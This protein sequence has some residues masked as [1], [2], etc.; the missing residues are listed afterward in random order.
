MFEFD[1]LRGDLDGFA[2]EEWTSDLISISRAKFSDV[3]NGNLPDWRKTLSLLPDAGKHVFDLRSPTI[4]S[5]FE[6][7]EDSRSLAR[8][9]LLQFRPW[10]KGPFNISGI[11]I[12]AEW[13]SDLK[14]KRLEKSISP[15]T[16]RHVLDVG[17]GNGYYALRMRGLGA[18]SV[19]GI[20][21]TLLHV[22]QF[23]AI[24][25][26]MRPEPVH[27][28]PLRLHELPGSAPLFDTTFSMGVLYHQRDPIEHLSQL[29]QTLRSGGELVLESL[30]VPGDTSYVV[31]PD[32]R[33]A[34]MRNVWHLPTVQRLTE[35][36][37]EAG[38]SD[39]HVVD[40]TYTT[41]DEQRT[42]EW[43][44]FESLIEALDPSDSSK[45]VEGL[46]APLR[47]IIICRNPEAGTP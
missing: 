4:E 40:Q 16:D 32:D 36:L 23:A 20:D 15:L 14:W 29:K 6:W 19:T 37:G 28:L 13:Q 22:I 41:M 46:P 44:Q 18:R 43:M 7:P 8:E 35:W 33:Y 17:C 42:T 25:H 11:K 3:S 39:M 34:R 12:D 45:T 9:K 30:I 27:V 1:R 47:A 10:R 24:T 2:A 38:F 21:P 5:H 26:F 31:I